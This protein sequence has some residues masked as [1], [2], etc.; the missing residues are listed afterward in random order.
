MIPYDPLVDVTRFFDFENAVRIGS[1]T[2]SH[3]LDGAIRHNPTISD[4][5][6]HRRLINDILVQYGGYWKK[7][8]VEIDGKRKHLPVV[9]PPTILEFSGIKVYFDSESDVKV[10]IYEITSAIWKY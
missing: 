8:D 5:I 2:E 10:R 9:S 7:W 3:I 1:E 6:N 4:R